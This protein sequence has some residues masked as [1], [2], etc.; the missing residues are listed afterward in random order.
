MLF[1]RICYSALVK[2]ADLTT[3]V[4]V[5]SYGIEVNMLVCYAIVI[6]AL[7]H[8]RDSST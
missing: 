1:T 5:G 6:E 7:T 3:A 4:N 2:L 8:C